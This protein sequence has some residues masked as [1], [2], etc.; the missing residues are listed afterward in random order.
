MNPAPTNYLPI[1]LSSVDLPVST[2]TVAL[3]PVLRASEAS[4][5]LMR[6]GMRCTTL[7]QLPVAFCAGISEN[8][9]PVAAPIDSTVPLMAPE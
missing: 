9:D 8:S 2:V 1:N 6:T 7:T 3:M 5:S 4:A